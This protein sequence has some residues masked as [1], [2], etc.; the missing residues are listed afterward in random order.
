MTV[1]QLTG[2]ELRTL[3]EAVQ[4]WFDFYQAESDENV[5]QTLCDAAVALYRD[6]HRQAADIA[7]IL[8]GTFIGPLSARVN[9]P[10]SASIH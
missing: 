9:A 2:S 3:S 6:G 4:R 8:I 10:S 7:T 5:S 1:D